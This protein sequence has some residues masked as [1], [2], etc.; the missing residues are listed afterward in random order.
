MIDGHV[1][2]ENGEL[3]VEYAMQFVN[4]A[5]KKGSRPCR[6]LTTRTAFWNLL[7]CM[8]ACAARPRCKLNG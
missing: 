4:A 5:A 2:L 3:S 8:K 6:S 7:P 1:H